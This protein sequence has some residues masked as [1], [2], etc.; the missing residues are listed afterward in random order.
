MQNIANIRVDDRLIHGQVSVLWLSHLQANRIMVIDDNVVTDDLLKMLLKVACPSSAKLSILS[1]A[2]AVS[3]LNNNKYAGDRMLIVVKE[4]KTILD[5]IEKGFNI[6]EVNLGYMGL[7]ENSVALSKQVYCT[8]Q[9]LIDLQRL[10]DLGVTLY[11][12]AIPDDKG[13]DV[14]KVVET[15][16]NSFH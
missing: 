1:V 5:I 11:A 16:L 13:F 6:T 7:R 14:R 2:T 3:N 9:N 12:K 15:L 4:P 10:I 8:K